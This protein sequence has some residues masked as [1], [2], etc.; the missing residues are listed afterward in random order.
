MSVRRVSVGLLAR[1]AG[2]ALG[3]VLLL[4]A[5]QALAQARRGNKDPMAEVQRAF[6]AKDYP[7]A[8]QVLRRLIAQQRDDGGWVARYNLALLLGSLERTREAGQELHK[9]I[10]AGFFD[11]RRLER[12]PAMERV[13]DEPIIAQQRADWDRVLRGQADRQV[14]RL[15]EAFGP[16][17]DV[18]RSTRLRSV[19]LSYADPRSTQRAKDEL[20]ELAEWANTNIFRGLLDPG[21][22]TLDPLIVVA[23]PPREV[24]K[25]WIDRRWREEHGLSAQREIHQPESE[26]LARRGT[27]GTGSAGEGARRRPTPMPAYVEQ[28]AGIYDPERVRLVSSDLGSSLRHEFFHGLHWRMQTRLGQDHP[29]WIKEGLA[30]LVEDM[31]TTAAGELRPVPSWRTNI[32]KRLLNSGILPD[33]T[34]LAALDQATFNTQRPL[35]KYAHARAFFLYLFDQDLLDRFW[36]VYTTDAEHGRGADERGVKAIEKVSGRS[37]SNVE[38][39]FR[40]WLV[41]LPMVAEE[42]QP[43]MASLGVSVESVEDGVMVVGLPADPASDPNDTRRSRPPRALPGQFQPGDVILAID[44]RS[45]RDVAELIRI[46][47]QFEPEQRV[48][49]LVRRA[50]GEREVLVTLRRK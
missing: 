24:F 49:V 14:V 46:L 6:D 4:T 16:G 30:T 38:R 21:Q 34:Q 35:A 31:D 5:P 1:L 50:G 40:R 10:E 18:T 48:R 15:Q 23:L 45:T 25:D 41:E 11:L 36:T 47:S 32:A 33:V 19:V 12:E 13:L 3:A 26:G 2:C 8:E 28:V 20:A 42:I 39:D 9:A 43:G 29:I 7:K 37:M 27:R 22:S 17:G 44:D